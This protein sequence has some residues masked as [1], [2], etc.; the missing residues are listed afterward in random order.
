MLVRILKPSEGVIDRISLSHLQLGLTYDLEDS[1][2][3]YL[4]GIGHAQQ[5][6]EFS[7]SAA[8]VSVDNPRAYEILTGGVVVIPQDAESVVERRPKTVRRQTT[9]DTADRREPRRR[10]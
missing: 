8:I 5:L 10:F 1:L 2:A 3:G 6:A 4:I 9:R 7:A